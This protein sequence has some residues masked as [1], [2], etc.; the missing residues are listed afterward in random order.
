[1]NRLKPLFSRILC[2]AFALAA[3]LTM[4]ACGGH[5]QTPPASVPAQSSA[6]GAAVL[7]EGQSAFT[8]QVVDGDG[9][10]TD[11]SSAR[12]NKP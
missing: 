11:F 6:D 4:T 1:M 8:L 3:A 10:Q 2:V 7:G 9:R 12:M 5:T